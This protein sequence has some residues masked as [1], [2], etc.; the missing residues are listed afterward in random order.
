MIP[1]MAEMKK[2]NSSG[3]CCQKRKRLQ[4]GNDENARGW[5]SRLRM[6]NGS[7]G[8]CVL[9]DAQGWVQQRVIFRVS[10]GTLVL[11]WNGSSLQEMRISGSIGKAAIQAYSRC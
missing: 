7:D 11:S 4:T 10:R 8:R 5:S 3:V 6:S 9:S 2:E 1:T